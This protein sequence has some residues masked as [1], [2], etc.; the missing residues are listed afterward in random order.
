MRTEP[1]RLAESAYLPHRRFGTVIRTK[2]LDLHGPVFLRPYPQGEEQAPPD[3]RDVRPSTS[4]RP[5][6]SP[7]ASEA[8]E[9]TRLQRRDGTAARQ[10]LLQSM[11]MQCMIANCKILL[12]I[13]KIKQLPGDEK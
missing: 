13:G 11:A 6:R 5:A 9:G 2:K 10:S 3:P 7:S 8:P 4:D 12:D 1:S